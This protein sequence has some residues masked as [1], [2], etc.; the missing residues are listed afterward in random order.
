LQWFQGLLA[1]FKFANRFA[2]SQLRHIFVDERCSAD[3]LEGPSN[4]AAARIMGNSVGE[5]ENNSVMTVDR[6]RNRI[7]ILIIFHDNMQS[8]GRSRT[9]R[10]CTRGMWRRG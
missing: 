2:P 4:K 9:T 6:A 3:C 7:D 1:K 8:G 10:T 5:L